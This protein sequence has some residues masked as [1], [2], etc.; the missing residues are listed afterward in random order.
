MTGTKGQESAA[1]HGKN[2]FSPSSSDSIPPHLAPAALRVA[3]TAFPLGFLAGHVV[4][5]ALQVFRPQV[6]ADSI[7][8]P[9]LV[10]AVAEVQEVAPWWRPQ[11]H[12][13]LLAWSTFHLLEFVITARYNSTR[14]MA[15]CE[16]HLRLLRSSL[17]LILSAAPAAFLISNGLSYHLAHLLGLFE[18]L[19]ESYLFPTLKQTSRWTYLG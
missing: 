10:S 13:Y 16:S 8:K 12:L 17:R 5:L 2:F 7:S 15:D 19:V 4:S 3:L 6:I 1:P 11:L 9:W 14:L 18:F